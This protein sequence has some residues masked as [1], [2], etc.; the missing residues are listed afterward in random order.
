MSSSSDSPTPGEDVKEAKDT[1]AIDAHHEGHATSCGCTTCPHGSSSRTT[2][3]LPQTE[4]AL[5]NPLYGSL[6][7]PSPPPGHPF[8][9]C[10]FTPTAAPSLASSLSRSP[11]SMPLTG[12]PS[13]VVSGGPSGIS[14]LPS[15]AAPPLLLDVAA[16]DGQTV[17]TSPH[18]V[19]HT[20]LLASFP[21]EDAMEATPHGVSFEAMERATAHQALQKRTEE[22]EGVSQ[23]KE[24]E[25]L[26]A[27]VPSLAGPSSGSTAGP[28]AKED[29]PLPRP[30]SG[31]SSTSDPPR[32]S[33]VL[34]QEKANAHPYYGGSLLPSHPTRQG[35]PSSSPPQQGESKKNE[36]EDQVVAE[37]NGKQ[38]AALASHFTATTATLPPPRVQEGTTDGHQRSE[39][40]KA[41][42]AQKGEADGTTPQTA[43][44]AHQKEETSLEEDGKAPQVADTCSAGS[45]SSPPSSVFHP[46]ADFALFAPVLVVDEESKE[47]IDH[48]Q[49]PEIYGSP[50]TAGFNFS[51]VSN[52]SNTSSM[53]SAGI[54]GYG[55]RSA[56][57]HGNA[58]SSSST[59][60]VRNGP[61]MSPMSFPYRSPASNAPFPPGRTPTTTTSHSPSPAAIGPSLSASRLPMGGGGPAGLSGGAG[62]ARGFLTATRVSTRQKKK[63]ALDQLMMASV[64]SDASFPPPSSTIPSIGSANANPASA[65]GNVLGI[66]GIKGP[67]FGFLDGKVPG[68]SSTSNA[69]PPHPLLHTGR[70]IPLSGMAGG[71]GGERRHVRGSHPAFPPVPVSAGLRD[72]LLSTVPLEATGS[73]VSPPILATTVIPS[74][75]SSRSSHRDSMTST[76]PGFPTSTSPSSTCASSS[77]SSA[78]PTITTPASMSSLSSVT[79]SPT[80]ATAGGGS[81]MGPMPVP[82]TSSE[83]APPSLVEEEG[84]VAKG[85]AE[86]SGLPTMW[87]PP[88]ISPPLQ[89]PILSMD[90]PQHRTAASFPFSSSTSSPSSSS[91]SPPAAAT[92]AATLDST[93]VDSLPVFSPPT[94]VSTSATLPTTVTTSALDYP[95]EHGKLRESSDGSSA[96]PLASDVEPN[97]TPQA[98]RV[99]HTTEPHHQNESEK[100]KKRHTPPRHPPLSASTHG[101]GVACSTA[102]SCSSAA[103]SALFS[104]S[105]SFYSRRSSSAISAAIGRVE[106]T[107][108]ANRDAPPISL[109]GHKLHAESPHGC[110]LPDPP[111]EPR[112]DSRSGVGPL[113]ALTSQEYQGHPTACSTATGDGVFGLEGGVTIGKEDPKVSDHSPPCSEETVLRRSLAV[114][115]LP[116]KE[117]R[118][119]KGMEAAE[120]NTVDTPNAATT[121]AGKPTKVKKEGQERQE[122]RSAGTEK[123]SVTRSSTT[124]P[125]PHAMGHPSYGSVSSLPSEHTGEE[126]QHHPTSRS[127][128]TSTEGEGR[129]GWSPSLNRETSTRSPSVVTPPSCPSPPPPPSGSYHSPNIFSTSAIPA[130]CDAMGV[131]KSYPVL[132]TSPPTPPPIMMATVGA[133]GLTA[134]GASHAIHAAAVVGSSHPMANVPMSGAAGPSSLH[135][136]PLY[137]SPITY[138]PSPSTPPTSSSGSSC[139]SFSPP[140]ASFASLSV[141]AVASATHPSS[142]STP[143]GAASPSVTSSL[144]SMMVPASSSS[145]VSE[146]VQR[147]MALL[148]SAKQTSALLFLEGLLSDNTKPTHAA[149]GT[150]LTSTTTNPA[151]VTTSSSSSPTTSTGSVP[152]KGGVGSVL[153]GGSSTSGTGGSARG[154]S[155][156]SGGGSHPHSTSPPAPLPLPSSFGPL[157]SPLD[158]FPLSFPSVPP[159][160]SGVLLPTTAGVST[161]PPSLGPSLATP[162]LGT[163]LVSPT[164]AT[165][166]GSPTATYPTGVAGG[167]PRSGTTAPVLPPGRNAG[168]PVTPLSTAPSGLAHSP[169]PQ[170]S[171]GV[172]THSGSSPSTGGPSPSH[173]SHS[174]APST[175]PMEMGTGGWIPSMPFTDDQDPLSMATEKEMVGPKAVWLPERGR[176]G[177]GYGTPSHLMGTSP[178]LP[179]PPLFPS[180]LPLGGNVHA[181]LQPSSYHRPPPHYPSS[182]SSGTSL[183]SLHE[184][185]ENKRGEDKRAGEVVALSSLAFPIPPSSM[186]AADPSMPAPPPCLHA[187]TSSS[188]RSRLAHSFL[189]G[190]GGALSNAGPPLPQRPA[191]G[192][193]RPPLPFSPPPSPTS[194][195]TSLSP[196]FPTA[197][198]V[199]SSVSQLVS[200]PHT[201]EGPTSTPSSVINPSL[202]EHALLDFPSV[203]IPR[204]SG[205]SYP[206]NGTPP[207][208][209]AP[210]FMGTTSENAAGGLLLSLKNTPT[211]SD[212]FAYTTC[213]NS[214]VNPPTGSHRHPAGGGN[215]RSVP[216]ES[217]VMDT[218]SG[219]MLGKM[220]LE[221]E[222][223]SSTAVHPSP[224]GMGGDGWGGGGGGARGAAV[225]WRTE[226]EGMEKKREESLPATEKETAMEAGTAALLAPLDHPCRT[227]SSPAVLSASSSMLPAPTGSV[228]TSIASWRSGSSRVPSQGIP[229]RP[230]AHPLSSHASSSHTSSLPTSL[231]LVGGVPCIITDVDPAACPDARVSHGDDKLPY[232]QD[233]GGGEEKGSQKKSRKRH[234]LLPHPSFRDARITILENGAHVLSPPPPSGE[235]ACLSVLPGSS[236]ERSYSGTSNAVEGEP[237]PHRT[238]TEIHREDPSCS[239]K[240]SG[241]FNTAPPGYLLRFP[242]E[243]TSAPFHPFSDA[244]R[245]VSG[246]PSPAVPSSPPS[247]WHMRVGNMTA[248]P[249][250]TIDSCSVSSSFAI[251]SV[252]SSSSSARFTD[253][254]SAITAL[255][256]T[257]KVPGMPLTNEG[258]AEKRRP[259][260]VGSKKKKK[261]FVA[262]STPSQDPFT[263][264]VMSSTSSLSVPPPPIS[265]AT[266]WSSLLHRRAA[267]LEQDAQR[268]RSRNPGSLHMVSFHGT[269]GGHHASSAPL[270]GTVYRSPLQ[271]ENLPISHPLVSSF[272]SSTDKSTRGPMKRRGKEEAEVSHYSSKRKHHWVEEEQK[273]GLLVEPHASE[274]HGHLCASCKKERRKKMKRD[275]KREEEGR[276]HRE[277]DA[278][279]AAIPMS[280]DPD[281]RDEDEEAEEEEEGGLTSQNIATSFPQR[282]HSLHHH[283]HHGPPA[284]RE[285][286]L[287]RIHSW[288]AGVDQEDREDEGEP[289]A[290]QAPLRHSLPRCSTYSFRP[291]TCSRSGRS[292]SCP[293]SWGSSQWE[294]TVR[295]HSHTR[296]RPLISS[297]SRDSP[298]DPMLH[299]SSV[300]SSSC[301]EWDPSCRNTRQEMENDRRRHVDFYSHASSPMKDGATTTDSFPRVPLPTSSLEQHSPLRVPHW[302]SLSKTD[303]ARVHEV[304]QQRRQRRRKGVPFLPFNKD[305]ASPPSSPMQPVFR[306]T[307]SSQPPSRRTATMPARSGSAHPFFA[308]VQEGYGS[309]SVHPRHRLG[310]PHTEEEEARLAEGPPGGS[311]ASDMKWEAWQARRWSAPLVSPRQDVEQ[312]DATA[313]RAESMPGLQDVDRRATGKRFSSA[314]IIVSSSYSAAP[315]CDAAQEGAALRF[316]QRHGGVMY[317]KE[318]R[319]D[320]EGEKFVDRE[321]EERHGKTKRKETLSHPH[322]SRMEKEEKI[323]IFSSRSVPHHDACVPC[324]CCGRTSSYR[325]KSSSRGGFRHEKPSEDVEEDEPEGE[326]VLRG[327]EEYHR[328]ATGEAHARR[329]PYSHRKDH[330]YSTP[331][332]V[333]RSHSFFPRKAPRPL[334]R[335]S[336][337]V[338]PGEVGAQQ[339]RNLKRT[340]KPEGEGRGGESQMEFSSRVTSSTLLAVSSSTILSMAFATSSSSS[341]MMRSAPETPLMQ[342]VEPKKRLQRSQSM[343]HMIGRTTMTTTRRRPFWR[344]S[345]AAVS[346]SSLQSSARNPPRSRRIKPPRP[347]AD[348]TEGEEKEVYMDM[349]LASCPS[350][351]EMISMDA[352]APLAPFTSPS[353]GVAALGKKQAPLGP[354][355]SGQ[356]PS[357]DTS[358]GASL[359]SSSLPPLGFPSSAMR[360]HKEATS[361]EGDASHGDGREGEEGTTVHQPGPSLPTTTTTPVIVPSGLPTTTL[362]EAA[363]SMPAEE[364]EQTGKD[365]VTEG[366][367]SAG[368]HKKRERSPASLSSAAEARGN[369]APS[370]P[371]TVSLSP[372][373]AAVVQEENGVPESTGRPS[374]SQGNGPQVAAPRPSSLLERY[375][376]NESNVGSSSTSLSADAPLSTSSAS[377]M[378]CAFS[379]AVRAEIQTLAMLIAQNKSFSHLTEEQ[380]TAL[381]ESFERKVLPKQCLVAKEGSPSL[382]CLFLIMDGRVCLERENKPAGTLAL[383]RFH[384][385]TEL[386]YHHERNSVTMRVVSESATLYTLAAEKYVS[387][388]K[389]RLERREELQQ[390]VSRRITLFSF[391]SSKA[392]VQLGKLF[393][394]ARVEQGMYLTQQGKPVNQMYIIMA[395]DVKVIWDVSEEKEAGQRGRSNAPLIKNRSA[396]TPGP[397]LLALSS[398]EEDTPEALTAV[399]KK[400]SKKKKRRKHGT[401]TPP[402]GASTVEETESRSAPPETGDSRRSNSQ[403]T[404]NDAVE[405]AGKGSGGSSR[406]PSGEK[407]PLTNG[408]PSSSSSKSRLDSPTVVA[409]QE[410]AMPT[411]TPFQPASPLPLPSRDALPVTG[412]TGTSCERACPSSTVCSVSASSSSPSVFSSRPLLTMSPAAPSGVVTI[413]GI[414]YPTFLSHGHESRN[415]DDAEE[416]EEEKEYPA[417]EIK[418]P[419]EIVGEVGFLF[420]ST[421]YYSAVA[422]TPLL[423]ATIEVNEFPT[424]VFHNSLHAMK[425]FIC[426]HPLYQRYQQRPT[427]EMT[428]EMQY[429]QYPLKPMENDEED[430]EE[431]EER[432]QGTGT[433]GGAVMQRDWSGSRYH[434]SVSS[435]TDPRHG[436]IRSSMDPERPCSTST[437]RH[438]PPCRVPPLRLHPPPLRFR[439]GIKEKI[440]HLSSSTHPRVSRTAASTPVGRRDGA[441]LAHRT[442]RDARRARDAV[443]LPHAPSPSGESRSLPL[444]RSGGPSSS[445]R[446]A[447]HRTRHQREER[448]HCSFRTEEG[449][450]VG[451]SIH[452][453]KR[454]PTYSMKEEPFK[455]S[456]SFISYSS[457][458]TSSFHDGRHSGPRPSSASV[459][460]SSAS[461]V[462]LDCRLDSRSVLESQAEKGEEKRAPRRSHVPVPAHTEGHD[463]PPTTSVV[464]DLKGEEEEG[465]LRRRQHFGKAKKRQGRR[466]GDAEGKREE[467]SELIQKAHHVH[468]WG[469][470]PSSPPAQSSTITTIPSSSL[471]SSSSY[472]YSSSY[473]TSSTCSC[474]GPSQSPRF[475][476]P[477]SGPSSKAWSMA[478]RHD[479]QESSSEGWTDG[480]PYSSSS[481][482]EFAEDTDVSV[483]SSTSSEWT[484][485]FSSSLSPS[486]PPGT[487]AM[488]SPRSTHLSSPSSMSYSPPSPSGP[489]AFAHHTGQPLKRLRSPASQVPFKTF[490]AVLP[491]AERT[492]KGSTSEMEGKG[493]GRGPV[494]FMH[495]SLAGAAVNSYV[496]SAP[497]PLHRR[498]GPY[499]MT[500]NAGEG[501]G[502][503]L[504]VNGE[505]K[506]GRRVENGMAPGEEDGNSGVTHALPPPPTALGGNRMELPPGGPERGFPSAMPYGTALLAAASSSLSSTPMNS[507]GEIVFSEQKR[508]FRFCADSL[509]TNG[510]TLVAVTTEGT[511]LRWNAVMQKITGFSASEAMSRSI[512]DFLSNDESR[513][514]MRTT[515]FLGAQHAAAWEE[516]VK[517]ELAHQSVFSFRQQTGLYTVGIAFSVIPSVC[518]NTGQVLLLIGRAA[519]L[520]SASHYAEDVTRW[521]ENLLA[522]QIRMCQESLTYIDPRYE[523]SLSFEG[524]ARLHAAIEN[525]THLVQQFI[526]FSRLNQESFSHA[527][528]PLRLTRLVRYFRREAWTMFKQTVHSFDVNYDSTPHFEVFMEP[529]KVMQVLRGMLYDILNAAPKG[530]LLNVVLLIT[531]LDPSDN[532]LH[533][534][535]IDVYDAPNP[536]L[537]D[538]QAS[539]AQHPFYQTPTSSQPHRTFHAGL[540]THATPSSSEGKNLSRTTASSHSLLPPS[541]T[542]ASS[543]SHLMLIDITKEA[544]IPLSSSSGVGLA[545]ST[546]TPCGTAS[547]VGSSPGMLDAPELQASSSASLKEKGAT[548]VTPTNPTTTTTITVSHL[549]TEG[550][551][552]GG[553]TVPTWDPL[554][555]PSPPSSL[556]PVT[557]DS[558]PFT[559]SPTTASEKEE[560]SEQRDEG[561]NALSF[562]EVVVPSEAVASTDMNNPGVHSAPWETSEKEQS[563]ALHSPF[564]SAPS[565]SFSFLVPLAGRG[566]VQGGSTSGGSAVV[567]KVHSHPTSPP[568]LVP[569]FGVNTECEA[570]APAVGIVSPS[571]PPP[572]VSSPFLS[573]APTLPP[574]EEDERGDEEEEK[575][576]TLP[577]PPDGPPRS[578]AVEAMLGLNSPILYQCMH[579]NLEFLCSVRRIRFEMR[580]SGAP[581]VGE[582]RNGQT[583]SSSSTSVPTT[584]S[585]T[586][587]ND[588]LTGETQETSG[589][590]KVQEEEEGQENKVDSASTTS[591][592][593]Y[594]RGDGLEELSPIIAELGGIL[595]GFYNKLLDSHVMRM[596][597]P[598]LLAPG[599]SVWNGEED[600]EGGGGGDKHPSNAP[601]ANGGNSNAASPGLSPLTRSTG[602]AAGGGGGDPAK[603]TTSSAYPHTTEDEDME[604]D[605][606]GGGA[607]TVIVADSNR[608]QTNTLCQILW[609]RQHAV[610]PVASYSELIRQLESGVSNILM[611]DPIN[612]TVSQQEMDLLRGDDPF[613]CIIDKAFGVVIVVMVSDWG[614]WRV[615][616]FVNLRNVIKLPKTGASAQIHIAIQ[617]AE[618]Q[619]AEIQEERE[620]FEI[621]RRTFTS[622]VPNRHKV[623]RLLG[624]GAFGDVFEVEDTLTGGKMAMKEMRLSNTVDPN[625]V[626][627]ELLAMTALQ[628]ENIIRY[629]FCEKASDFLLQVYMEVA[630]GGTLREKVRQCPKGG[631]LPIKDIAH[632]L[633]DACKGLAYIHSQRYVHRDIKTANLLL[634]KSNRVK[635]G[636]FG[637]AKKIKLHDQLYRLV[638]TPQYIAPEVVCANSAEMIGYSFKVDIWSLGCVAL[639]LATGQPPFAHLDR[640]GG[641]GIIKYLSELTTD[642]DITPVKPPDPPASLTDSGDSSVPPVTTSTSGSPTTHPFLYEFIHACFRL[643]PNLRPTAEQLLEFQLFHHDWA[644]EERLMKE[645]AAG[646][647]TASS[648]SASRT[649]T[650]GGGGG[651]TGEETWMSC[652]LMDRDHILL[653]S[654]HAAPTTATARTPS[655][656]HA[657]TG[658]HKDMDS[659]ALSAGEPYGSFSSSFMGGPPS[660]SA[661]PAIPLGGSMPRMTSGYSHSSFS[662]SLSGAQQSFS[663]TT[664]GGTGG[665]LLVPEHAIPLPIGSAPLDRHTSGSH[666]SISARSIPQSTRGREGKEGG[667]IRPFPHFHSTTKG[668]HTLSTPVSTALLTPLNDVSSTPAPF[669]ELKQFRRHTTTITS[670]T[671]LH[672]HSTTSRG[673][674]NTPLQL[675][676]RSSSHLNDSSTSMNSAP[677]GHMISGSQGDFDEALHPVREGLG[678]NKSPMVG[679]GVDAMGASPLLGS[680]R[681]ERLSSA[682]L[683]NR[684]DRRMDTTTSSSFSTLPGTSEKTRIHLS[685]SPLLL[686][687]KE[688]KEEGVSGEGGLH[689]TAEAPLPCS[690][691]IASPSKS[692]DGHK[693]EEAPHLGTALNT[694]MASRTPHR[695]EMFAT[696][697]KKEEEEKGKPSTARKAEGERGPS[698]HRHHHLSA[699]YSPSTPALGR[700]HASAM[701]STS[702][703][704]GVE[705]SLTKEAGSTTTSGPVH[706]AH[707]LPSHDTHTKTIFMSNPLDATSPLRTDTTTPPPSTTKEKHSVARKGEPSSS[708]HPAKSEPPLREEGHPAWQKKETATGIPAADH[709]SNALHTTP[710]SNHTPQKND[711]QEKEER[712]E[713][714][715]MRWVKGDF[716]SDSD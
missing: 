710:S 482:G 557:P 427:P 221:A 249:T 472:T 185:L 396:G 459:V 81:G 447:H 197:L 426:T 643:D 618:K 625:A 593:P 124:L 27:V 4:V 395:G 370:S 220:A 205:S 529:L 458:S 160:S 433:G 206:M 511:I 108:E 646:T 627:Q 681:K 116:K 273:E 473:S 80:T 153:L 656:F 602:V 333:Y 624:K 18:S 412:S 707:P 115:P 561:P 584:S 501:K 279:H 439:W 183:S 670:S 135:A 163:R 326:Q 173:R 688:V 429:M 359:S 500:D 70:G 623:V 649:K 542:L 691:S 631:G 425:H 419:G 462:P 327:A 463:I 420:K 240:R 248:K 676:H 1:T 335:A 149:A 72:P 647:A 686:A 413:N 167:V 129:H 3:S 43:E 215:V 307:S 637:T 701:P 130:G 159:L 704:A 714:R 692:D 208:A 158:R 534:T 597:L 709:T 548:A 373:V 304:A 121:H 291:F 404:S 393:S 582:G 507:F 605:L 254:A 525:T 132:A 300:T 340:P 267:A 122:E 66:N 213:T 636:D 120:G 282:H 706:H 655:F 564:L 471:S 380:L 490:S 95:S 550:S 255:P 126:M 5:G 260:P 93:L 485:D 589:G 411:H 652:H 170:S 689:L 600:E 690:F 12:S 546:V 610:I 616:K 196:P 392:R 522:P 68:P 669:S 524:F 663:G 299:F 225:P 608:V 83:Q 30:R 575:K 528:R 251:V 376:T 171:S 369:R 675:S 531:I 547:R 252:S 538:S 14:L 568:A 82:K 244:E 410:G 397:Y 53:S 293:H 581:I 87:R 342:N 711:D 712:G 389:K 219:S 57:V 635:I 336:Y 592:K 660:I 613:D 619:A 541:A 184:T 443:A 96:V 385:E 367:E 320:E 489:I 453:K 331:K 615:Q 503:A 560:S 591:S 218:W 60:V 694:P 41:E 384:G 658:S 242:H 31:R 684:R 682:L 90:P 348:Y 498:S 505:E 29:P 708:P 679:A 275:A 574:G 554:A 71:G 639:E 566:S 34:E 685:V 125:M 231:S 226:E 572:P 228:P 15:S 715:Q 98:K 496:S 78:S 195:P 216:P 428:M 586:R 442:Q 321:T 49:A 75:P 74:H 181:P 558:L 239:E 418:G 398:P 104:L 518:A 134:S 661:A 491:V 517:Q 301:M 520:R 56:N 678:R 628:H 117:E 386:A 270:K 144:P 452:S 22:P 406:S 334:H 673:S 539:S 162:P 483:G 204:S 277:G 540:N 200:T 238:R 284:R 202:V 536:S 387:F 423:V 611:I 94:S 187:S 527:L 502:G 40:I 521:L 354:T 659:P 626:L 127:S 36:Q 642:P 168:T 51:P 198:G 100:E 402:S 259:R 47:V 328:S 515:I 188:S 665:S 438:R 668:L 339:E 372:A 590:E 211:P 371:H 172:S 250:P 236:R 346:P 519:Q 106:G 469:S 509:D 21:L 630:E 363:T 11:S 319:E 175:V 217:V 577:R 86:G 77:S 629:F 565:S 598:L 20:P 651:T 697:T 265:A 262:L 399:A 654:S 382:K 88:F 52:N 671:H 456:F 23:G 451:E 67:T 141:N 612:V 325:Q 680:P 388:V 9:P 417:T 599:K 405:V 137:S 224:N 468:E 61:Y 276:L 102:S 378:P 552:E 316:P 544:L 112:S 523:P 487:A 314:P 311:K 212:P 374:S 189:P 263:G 303:R 193:M 437:R 269:D 543:A 308:P 383:R 32:L 587:R 289:T 302:D 156:S 154:T 512:F 657:S 145:H 85:Y 157:K 114:S 431:E 42:E 24:Q 365:A 285:G 281:E 287:K 59:S 294:E 280:C 133:A 353:I 310:S 139:G 445:T 166:A 55:T 355:S 430:E 622:A 357:T 63:T 350:V 203:Y 716:F 356:Q 664:G 360:G 155:S 286:V 178:P 533:D 241:D 662:P 477:P 110:I 364:M 467:T 295:T 26:M 25:G 407:S 358:T 448:S 192:R 229:G 351:G 176:E 234:P 290:P 50:F 174:G 488:S 180:D 570:E 578:P 495:P 674:W 245:E 10:P 169:L 632:Y 48:R 617:M 177:M 576:P 69:Y 233:V 361:L 683:K 516:Y 391:L 283:H 297:P 230:I 101:K 16:Q 235:G 379:A 506:G 588:P 349:I 306:W 261:P 601:M 464:R 513:Q 210:P 2:P 650:G 585:T 621:I 672:N 644:A 105:S 408:D 73:T 424:T 571:P 79:V 62:L 243:N 13:M 648:P 492:P 329:S 454:A 338:V 603:A 666:T 323:N 352:T 330:H 246:V 530:A 131:L 147:I 332:R 278:T 161:A 312:P 288:C 207:P 696:S 17:S 136:T 191:S 421:A 444:D 35:A 146:Q 128:H 713:P 698:H 362:E 7:Y 545:T 377:C 441:S 368:H 266:P 687:E 409:E 535:D 486:F 595:Y 274:G 499:Y 194:S 38:D 366:K 415:H 450:A 526:R 313:G 45:P 258:G 343:K 186:I 695:R 667:P 480:P 703:P 44:V 165:V 256:D 432:E 510:T 271:K 537:R 693:K 579:D 474:Q 201:G 705:K 179:P 457:V 227:S 143:G 190:N 580:D 596:E 702:S 497:S 298:Y 237:H 401:A 222:G 322:P 58:S 150:S 563:L 46:D 318:R 111:R 559:V 677:M 455:T 142:T 232:R 573:T 508:L 19:F 89:D 607:Q 113:P 556:H 436:K 103:S 532:V 400:E 569:P 324:A 403:L 272:A 118:T 479:E 466:R 375:P 91:T 641:M 315:L 151:T 567:M 475:A 54:I 119:E 609:A 465:E 305:I 28:S 494:H 633:H 446:A 76:R 381:L 209:L 440:C 99:P 8:P 460:S 345:S 478:A 645:P 700:V 182:S 317:S 253:N 6:T 699:G 107:K 37:T 264:L 164:T 549:A 493:E 434:N 620:R 268:K 347:T 562:P 39:N 65:G 481:S 461:S 148:P 614:D 604:E 309:L 140:P 553:Q 247:P 555:S 504:I 634:D 484:N 606:F 292:S 199:P 341:S 214:S 390:W 92:L 138:A 638:G 394:F 476:R 414:P 653:R 257:K 470:T 435:S 109:A 97:E 64:A 223:A 123:R 551:V 296:Y 416:D 422:L 583:P 344:S 640:T 337:S 449:Q 152:H 84:V 594:Q 33:S 514:R